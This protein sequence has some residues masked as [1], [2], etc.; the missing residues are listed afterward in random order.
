MTNN[1]KSKLEETNDPDA[2]RAVISKLI[3][4]REYWM[5]QLD[6]DEAHMQFG[7][8]EDNAELLKILEGAE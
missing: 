5:R 2:L 6:G 3:E 1:L 4:Q 8:N 7:L